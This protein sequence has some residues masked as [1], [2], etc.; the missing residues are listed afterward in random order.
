MLLLAFACFCLLL[1]AFVCFC[2]FICFCVLL[3]A[4]ACFCNLVLAEFLD[5]NW[6]FE[7]VWLFFFSEYF[8]Q[9]SLRIT[10]RSSDHYLSLF[11]IFGLWEKLCVVQV[12]RNDVETPFMELLCTVFE[13]RRKKSHS[14]LRAKRA[15]FTFWVD[16][17]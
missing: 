13:N 17:S 9:M 3:C 4:F 10:L 7:I 12:I 6:S 2:Q 16:K 8:V 11:L 14:T 5:K 1:S 15:T